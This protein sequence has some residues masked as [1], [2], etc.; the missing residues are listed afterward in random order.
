MEMKDSLKKEL[1]LYYEAPK[2]QEKQ[3]FIR[4]FGVQK[5]DIF[6]LSV[7]QAKYISKWVWICSIFFCG[8]L[9]GLGTLLEGRYV[10]TIAAFLPFL[11]MLS[12]TESTRSYR[13]GM[14]ELELS[15]RFSLKSIVM[16]RMCILGMGNMLV[17]VFAVMC[18]GRW[19]ESNFLY[20]ITPYFLSVGGGFY[21]VRTVRGRES[22]FFCFGLA[23]MISMLQALL[24]FYFQIIFSAEYLFMWAVVCAVAVI[25]TGREGHRMLQMTECLA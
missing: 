3:V 10:G 14:E 18:I 20:M 5:I 16:A 22:V 25:V 24:P 21:I 7:K 9:Y 13:H 2:P 17:L 19:R 8:L 6:S 15:A 11:V 23:G 1:E 12:V 4:Q